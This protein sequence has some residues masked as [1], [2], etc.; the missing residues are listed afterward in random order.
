[1][2]SDSES[3]L[4]L[5]W[6]A[7]SII[8]NFFRQVFCLHGF[9]IF[10]AISKWKWNVSIHSSIYEAQ[11]S[12]QQTHLDEVT[13]KHSCRFY[14]D[15]TTANRIATCAA[16]LLKTLIITWT[17]GWWVEVQ[18]HNFHPH[19]HCSVPSFKASSSMINGKSGGSTTA[20][21]KPTALVHSSELLTCAW[22][23]ICIWLC[24]L[25]W[26]LVGVC[27]GVNPVTQPLAMFVFKVNESLPLSAARICFSKECPPAPVNIGLACN[28]RTPQASWSPQNRPIKRTY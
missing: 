11:R 10:V 16:P 14:F 12:S 19:A 17:H 23:W 8:L 20:S 28:T 9:I 15:E 26:W 5:V 24:E 6:L 7:A 1:M 18:C 27:R 3:Q 13:G 22:A 4:E 21:L 25:V 2:S